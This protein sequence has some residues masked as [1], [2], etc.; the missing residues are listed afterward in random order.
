VR[1]IV[2]GLQANPTL[3]ASTAIIITFDEG[4]GYDIPK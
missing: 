3:W 1:K 4:G 2:D